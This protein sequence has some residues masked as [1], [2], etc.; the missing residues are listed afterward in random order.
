[1]VNNFKN[2]H[3]EWSIT[4]GISI[5]TYQNQKY[6]RLRDY[7][8]LEEYF[9]FSEKRALY[10]PP[11]TKTKFSVDLKQYFGSVTSGELGVIFDINYTFIRYDKNPKTKPIKVELTTNYAKV[12]SS[13]NLFDRRHELLYNHVY[14]SNSLDFRGYQV[15]IQKIFD[16]RATLPLGYAAEEEREWVNRWSIAARNS[17]DISRSVLEKI[18]KAAAGEKVGVAGLR[19]NV[20]C[21]GTFYIDRIAYPVAVYG[22]RDTVLNLRKVQV[23]SVDELRTAACRPHLR[24]DDSFE[25]YIALAFYEEGSAEPAFVLQVEKAAEHYKRSTLEEWLRFLNILQ[26]P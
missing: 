19:K 8:Y 18:Q 11:K 2:H 23:A 14:Q 17:L 22:E 16:K 10:L 21:V 6:F 5:N 13:L 1:M 25:K 7:G 26:A 24:Y 3:F 4:G 20:A 9:S 12:K 15:Q